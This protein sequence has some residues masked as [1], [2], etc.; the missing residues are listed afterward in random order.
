L[1]GADRILLL[2]VPALLLLH[3]GGV[4]REEQYLEKKARAIAY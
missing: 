3:Y 4:K 1:L 2:M